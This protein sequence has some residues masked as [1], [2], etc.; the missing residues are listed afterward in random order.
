MRVKRRSLTA[1]VLTALAFI[2]VLS[3]AS[4]TSAPY[5]SWLGGCWLSESGKALEVWDMATPDYAFGYH[6]MTHEEDIVFFEQMRISPVD[7]KTTFFAYPN[8]VGPSPFPAV[9]W[10]EDSITFANEAHDYP[11]KITYRMDGELLKA[12]ISKMDGSQPNGWTFKRC[13]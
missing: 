2:P 11:Q 12:T 1:S 8:G 9:K 7:G 5:V 4:D 6:T 3:V 13:D 10:S